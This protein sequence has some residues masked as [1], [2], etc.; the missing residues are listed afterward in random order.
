MLSAVC[1]GGYER[2]RMGPVAGSSAFFIYI[3][4]CRLHDAYPPQHVVQVGDDHQQD[5][6]GEAD[7]FGAYHEFLAG[8]SAGDDFVEQEYHVSAVQC[9]DG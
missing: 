4:M 5:E 8:R 1:R 7:V 3:I 6:D 2:R 9:R